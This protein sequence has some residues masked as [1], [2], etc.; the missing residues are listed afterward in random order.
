VVAVMGGAVRRGRWRLAPSCRVINLM[1]G[2]DLDLT[3]AE[4]GADQVELT[5]ISVMGGS[6]IRVPESLAV[7]VSK[8]ALMG[9]NEV[10]LEGGATDPGGPVLH[11]RLISIMG[12]ADVRRGPPA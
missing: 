3:D 6:R 5:V 7:E 10:R 2:A 8:L 4:L 11:L 1:G 12:G 9:G